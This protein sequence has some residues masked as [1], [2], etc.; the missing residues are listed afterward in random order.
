MLFPIL[1]SKT[2]NSSPPILET[3][4]LSTYAKQINN[5]SGSKVLYFNTEAQAIANVSGTDI[6][7]LNVTSSQMVYARITI[8]TCLLIIPVTFTLVKTPDVL[9]ELTINLKDICDNN[10]DGKENID[11]SS[12]AA[13]INLN[14]ELVDFTYYKT[15]NPLN[16]TF[17]NPY[18]N[19]SNIEVQDGSIIYV[20]VKYKNSDCFSVSKI[21]VNIDYLPTIK[22]SK[23]VTLKACDDDFNFGEYFDLAESTPQLYDQNLNSVPL[24]DLI[25]TYYEPKISAYRVCIS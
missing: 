14:N 6:K 15:Y 4:T 2:I 12:Y 13:E 25:I 3:V 22:L 17:S 7:S 24:S 20:K 1:S 11:L 9:Y 8:R 21:I 23:T 16:N 18:F 10:A 19:I 5:Q